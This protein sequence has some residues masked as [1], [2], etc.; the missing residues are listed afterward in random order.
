MEHILGL[1]LDLF[2]LLLIKKFL[3]KFALHYEGNSCKETRKIKLFAYSS[4][5]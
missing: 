5:Y 1:R 2:L 3:A 4:K